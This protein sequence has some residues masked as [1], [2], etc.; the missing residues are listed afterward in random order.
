MA[1]LP[2]HW[3]VARAYAQ[4]TE[5]EERVVQALEAAVS[6]GVGSRDTLEGQFGNPVVVL[7]RRIERS[8]DLRSTW[9]RWRGAGLLATLKDDLEE[10][11]DDDGVLHFRVDKQSA[12]G[13]TLAP[14]RGA[15]PIDIQ[16]KLKAYPAKAEEVRRV[17]RA[18]LAEAD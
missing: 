5:E 13:G 4:A 10:R 18:L 11:L 14:A 2:I 3:I 1:S 12:F 7:R 17:A 15:D 8:E 6:G 9:E 16:V